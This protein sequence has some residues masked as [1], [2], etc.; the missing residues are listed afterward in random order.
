MVIKG[1]EKMTQIKLPKNQELVKEVADFLLVQQNYDDKTKWF[2]YYIHKDAVNVI[3]NY[4]YVCFV[5]RGKYSVLSKKLER[6]IFSSLNDAFEFVR[7][8]WA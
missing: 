8:E 3:G 2:R 6:N 4:G 7:Q 5:D 1:E